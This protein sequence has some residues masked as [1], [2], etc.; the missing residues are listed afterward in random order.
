M[1]SVLIQFKNWMLAGNN[2]CSLCNL[3][4]SDSESRKKQQS[5]P[6]PGCKGSPGLKSV[7]KFKEVGT[8]C[9]NTSDCYPDNLLTTRIDVSEAV[10][11]DL[12]PDYWICLNVLSS[13]IGPS[14]GQPQGQEGQEQGL[15]H[16]QDQRTCTPCKVLIF[17]ATFLL[18]SKG[19]PKTKNTKRFYFF[20]TISLSFIFLQNHI[21]EHF[22]NC[23]QNTCVLCNVQQFYWQQRC[24]RVLF[25]CVGTLEL[26]LRRK[27][28]KRII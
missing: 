28:M 27:A 5:E 7:Q 23:W 11:E 15:D 3:Q 26:K 13:T 19:H 4:W 6:K 9:D 14:M 17:C 24:K 16:R 2:V 22:S 20:A 10:K 1:C 21:S 18:L 8:Q 25:F 12:C